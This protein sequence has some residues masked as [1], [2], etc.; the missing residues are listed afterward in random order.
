ML[1]IQEI[2]EK[3]K[4]YPG[5]TIFSGWIEMHGDLLDGAQKIAVETGTSLEWNA[6]G[7][8]R[9][10]PK[11]YTEAEN[12]RKEWLACGLDVADYGPPIKGKR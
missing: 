11:D 10:M 12:I 9:F 5:Y 8:P 1:T 3:I 7:S 6:G 2:T 4:K